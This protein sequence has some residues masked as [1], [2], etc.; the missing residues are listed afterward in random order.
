MSVAPRL[1]ADLRANQRAADARS[2]GAYEELLGIVALPFDQAEEQ[3]VGVMRDFIVRHDNA[4]AELW[5]SHARN[6]YVGATAISAGLLP[7]AP[8]ELYRSVERHVRDEFRHSRYFR[9]LAKL[10]TGVWPEFHC[11]QLRARAL[12]E[13]SGANNLLEFLI[14][15]NVAEIRTYY[16]LRAYIAVAPRHMRTRHGRTVLERILLDEMSHIAYTLTAIQQ[17]SP[18]VTAKLI[19]RF[20]WYQRHLSSLYLRDWPDP[21]KS[22]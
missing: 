22:G 5:A 19:E 18:T 2:S 3:V 12:A 1:V 4:L 16:L 9:A 7:L 10:E 21:T 14:A 6:E 15:T 13:A 11:G 20:Q 17:I 8:I